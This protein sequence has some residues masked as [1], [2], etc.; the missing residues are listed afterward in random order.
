MR[1][2]VLDIGCSDKSLENILEK[3]CKY[4]GLD[5]L[6]TAKEMYNTTPDIYG[7]AHNLPIKSSS[8]DSITL[9]DVLE[10]LDSPEEC[11]LEIQRILKPGGKLCL[12]APFLYPIHDA[13]YDFQRWTQFGLC[14]L[15][16]SNNFGIEAIHENGSIPT[17]LTLL[18]NLGIS[19][20]T[21]ELIECSR[22]FFLLILI[23]LPL[24][25]LVNISGYLLGIVF[26]NKSFMPFGYL[27]VCQK[28]NDVT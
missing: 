12:Q 4:I 8:I 10:H 22:I 16:K 28:K 7:D 11:I 6:Q 17:T 9:L 15:L 19:K 25:L 27:I 23:T 3:S 21:T 13:P 18:I 20:T 1:G 26:K 5:Y 14:K 24:I 2:T